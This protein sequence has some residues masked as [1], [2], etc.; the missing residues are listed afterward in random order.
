MKK[1]MK[2]KHYAGFLFWAGVVIIKCDR[3][4]VLNPRE[5]NRNEYVGVFRDGD[6]PEYYVGKYKHYKEDK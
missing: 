5:Y 6:C 2:C 4:K 3:F 1:C